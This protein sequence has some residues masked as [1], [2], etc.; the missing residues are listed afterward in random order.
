MKAALFC[1]AE[2]NHLDSKIQRELHR[3]YNLLEEYAHQQG[4]SIEY[5]AFHTDSFHLDSPDRVLLS[6]MQNAQAE[7]FDLILVES[8]TCFPLSQPDLLPPIRLFIQQEHQMLEI[9]TSSTP[10]IQ[11]YQPQPVTATYI[12]H[13]PA[14]SINLSMQ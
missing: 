13:S 4:F 3:Q 12:R 7:K 5:T 9:G 14:S 2:G 8:K 1:H 11:P 10:L 6:L